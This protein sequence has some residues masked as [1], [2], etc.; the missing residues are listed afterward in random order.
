MVLKS[1]V[2]IAVTAMKSRRSSQQRAMRRD[3]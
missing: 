1:G 2:F 3:E